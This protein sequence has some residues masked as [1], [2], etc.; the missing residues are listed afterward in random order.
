MVRATRSS[1]GST[2]VTPEVECPAL[3]MSRRRRAPLARA[4]VDI[5]CDVNRAPWR[6]S[7]EPCSVRTCDDAVAF[8][9]TDGVHQLAA[10]SDLSKLLGTSIST[11]S[12]DTCLPLSIL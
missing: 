12:V 3:Q 10:A 9:A 11:S 4:D 5:L 8:H 2:S 6:Q 1:T 7:P